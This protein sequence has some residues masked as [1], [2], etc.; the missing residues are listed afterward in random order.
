MGV[1]AITSDGV[2][3][4]RILCD[5]CGKVLTKDSG[6]A[7]W[8]PDQSGESSDVKFCCVGLHCLF[9]LDR[10]YDAHHYTTAH[11]EIFFDED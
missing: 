4:I 8:I 2:T 5:S 7:A 11:L 10:M 6:F 1:K 3:Q 9:D